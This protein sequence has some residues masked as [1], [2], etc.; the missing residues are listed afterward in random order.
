MNTN[1][2]NPAFPLPKGNENV[3]PEVAGLTKREYFAAMAMQGAMANPA[4]MGFAS[5]SKLDPSEIIARSALKYAD[6][7]IVELNK[8]G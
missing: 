8:N 5:A 3:A 7:L 4:S 2:N 6:A 1:S